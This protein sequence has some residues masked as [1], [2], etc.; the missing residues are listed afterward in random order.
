MHQEQ[1][2]KDKPQASQTQN[3]YLTDTG[4]SSQPAML[5]AGTSICSAFAADSGSCA[6]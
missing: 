6:T 4:D 1:L 3:A 2:D 5:M